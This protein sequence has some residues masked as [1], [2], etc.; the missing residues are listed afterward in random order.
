MLSKEAE[1]FLLSL[2]LELLSRGKKEK[3]IQEIAEELR[4]H[5]IEA[6]A[7][8]QSVESITGGSVKNYIR[9]ISEELPR[10]KGFIKYSILLLVYLLGVFII[11]DLISG[12]FELNTSVILYNLAVLIIGT[13]ATII[14]FKTIAQKYGDSKKTYFILMLFY[15]PYMAALVGGQFIIRNHPGIVLAESNFIVNLIIGAVLLSIFII[16]TLFMKQWFLAI[17]IFLMCLPSVPD[18]MAEFST[19][20]NGSE[21]ETYLIISGIV[22]IAVNITVMGIFIYTSKKEDKKISN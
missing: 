3:D 7:N 22:L 19:G 4:D 17:F 5:L 8:G 9:S 1:N 12:D 14:F 13:A 21:N 2:R 15:A 11:P 6:E 16:V 20:S 18:I 10:D